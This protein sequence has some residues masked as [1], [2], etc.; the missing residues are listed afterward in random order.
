MSMRPTGSTHT[1]QPG[2]WIMRTAGGS[3]CVM[4][5]RAIA[6]VWP[7]QNSMNA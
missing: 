1:G 7:P 3:S 6:C 2:P 4:P 5:W